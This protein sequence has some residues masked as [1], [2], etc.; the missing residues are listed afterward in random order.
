[1][2]VTSLLQW[3]HTFYSFLNSSTNWDPK[4]QISDSMQAIFNQTTT[5]ATSKEE[6][7][8]AHYFKRGEK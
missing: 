3:G 2:L 4:I 6:E 1:M 7:I 5:I 8:K